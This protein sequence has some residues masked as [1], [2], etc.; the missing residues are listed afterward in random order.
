VVS[1]VA[2][3]LN[4]EG[5]VADATGSAAPRFLG[6]LAVIMPVCLLIQSLVNHAAYRQPL[7]P[8]VVWLGMLALA[9]RLVPRAGAGGLG[10]ADAVAAVGI[11]VVAVTAIGLDRRAQTAARTVDWTILGVVWL[12]ALIALSGPAR[13]WV[14]GSALVL[15]VHAVFVL[16]TLGVSPLGLARLAAS[17]YAIGTILAVFAAVRSILRTRAE[18]A[19]RHAELVSRSAAERAAVAAIHK[20]RRDRLALLEMEALPLLRG[21]AEGTLD[22]GERTV[23]RQ[24]AHHAV[25]LRRALADRSQRASGLLAGLEPALRAARVR[26]VH[27]EIQV[28]GDPA[29]PIEAVAQ[30]ALAAVD[31]V[32]STL[33]PQWAILTVLGSGDEVELY[34]TFDRAPQGRYDMAGP[35]DVAGLGQADLGGLGQADLGGLGQADLGGL[36]QADLG[37][38]GQAAAA[39]AWWATVEVDQTGRGCLEVHWRTVVPA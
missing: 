7:V 10:T 30:A 27:V 1:P 11:A 23:R 22:P 38:L 33:S 25:T 21:I 19:V 29:P 3:V 6:A 13:V 16:R 39:S 5:V 31:G 35:Y 8:V 14:P 28:I 34:L 20:D 15:A 4:R 12:L 26:D 32:L 17:G 37:G 9:A 2:P 24:C 36:G 18:M